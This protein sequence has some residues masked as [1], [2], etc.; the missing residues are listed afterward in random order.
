VKLPGRRQPWYASVRQQSFNWSAEMKTKAKRAPEA[1]IQYIKIRGK[2][3]AVVLGL[4]DFRALMEHM[5]D[6][7]DSLDLQEA[8]RTSTGFVDWADLKK[9]LLEKRHSPRVS[10]T[11]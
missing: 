2:P 8:K 10:R 9:E 6:L 7:E 5:E 4:P 1:R 3:V 11:R